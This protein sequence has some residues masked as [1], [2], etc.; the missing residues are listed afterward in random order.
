MRK[1]IGVMAAADCC[2]PVARPGIRTEEA[3]ALA[4]LF[5]ALGD[6]SRVRIVNLLA[7]AGHLDH[8]KVKA[9]KPGG[10]WDFDAVCAAIETP[11]EAS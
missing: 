4:T 1:A 7:K 10:I 3:E 5:R 11:S 9:V 2:R 6:P 8:L